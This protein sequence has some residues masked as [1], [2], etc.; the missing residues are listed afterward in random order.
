MTDLDLKPNHKA[1]KDYYAGLKEFDRHGVTH[2][3]AVRSAFQRL[4]EH[5]SGKVGWTFIG[6][7]S[8][9]RKGRNP[10]SIDGGMVDAFTI[11][12]AFWEAK[13]TKDDLAKEVQNK[14]SVGYPRDNIIF[15][16]PRRAILSQCDHSG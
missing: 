1:V 13:D 7:Y 12:Q 5:C 10:A 16:E 6:E 8:Y 9:P 15:Q 2:E 11:P 14:F 3:G 4:L